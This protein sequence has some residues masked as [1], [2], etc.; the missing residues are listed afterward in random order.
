MKKTL[1]L[2]IAGIFLAVGVNGQ[3]LL[4]VG[5]K[6]LIITKAEQSNAFTGYFNITDIGLIIGSTNNSRVAPFTFLTTNGYHFTEQFSGGLG[7]G[8]EFI[9]GSYLPVVLDARY[10]IRNTSFSP[11]LSLYG[12]YTHPLDDDGYYNYYNWSSSSSF[13]Y[14]AYSSYEATGGWLLNPGFGIRKMF[15]PDFGIIFSVGYRIQRLYYKGDQ[16]RQLY[17]DSNRLTMKIGITFR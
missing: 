2:L 15:S 17:A 16:D 6:S 10:Y 1:L 5:D 8:L 3:T 11:F 14:E 12:G 4:K 7:I 9:A 13:D